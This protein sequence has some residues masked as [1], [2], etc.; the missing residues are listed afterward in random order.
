MDA[1]SRR[2][3]VPAQVSERMTMRARTYAAVRLD[4][5]GAG[6]CL[7]VLMLEDERPLPSGS[8]EAGT[9]SLT[10]VAI[11]TSLNPTVT[12]RLALLLEDLG[13]VRCDAWR[14]YR[15]DLALGTVRGNARL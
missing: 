12:A 2:F 9:S 4:Q 5:V 1:Q 7:G 15:H 10:E 13:E 14:Q 8:S 6:R 3:G 11:T